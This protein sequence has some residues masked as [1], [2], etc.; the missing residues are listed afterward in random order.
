MTFSL[1]NVIG[2]AIAGVLIAYAGGPG[3]AL[4]FD[5]A[6]FA[7]SLVLL[8]PLRPRVVERAMAEEDPTATTSHFW[9][10]LREG[11]SEV[12]G[13]SWVVGFLLGM[14]AYHV[15]VL[16]SIFV[17]GPVL[18]QR[19][20]DGAQSW[21]LITVFFG[22]GNIL[23]DLLL[24]VWRPRFALRMAA[25]MLVGSSLRRR[26]SAVA[27]GLD[28]RGARAAHGICVTCAFTLWETSLGEHIPERSLSRVSSYD[29]LTSAG[30]IPLGNLAG[31]AG[32]RR[33][34]RAPDPGRDDRDRCR[35]S[36]WPSPRS[37]RCADLPRGALEVAS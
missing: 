24:L 3:G 26:S 8:L 12:V 6:T 7:V 4:V 32:D 34:R 36:P 17:I 22:I 29:Y 9:A 10:S 1:G 2:P 25:L 19:E 5:A 16:P 13:R 14:A 33:V 28:D 27:W 20:Y 31:R 15:V 21:A 35:R 11:W 18:M 23:G 30:L 37:R